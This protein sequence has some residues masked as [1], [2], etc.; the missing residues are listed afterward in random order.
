MKRLHSVLG[1]GAIAAVLLTPLILETP[2]MAQLQQAGQT[3][4]QTL[5]RQPQMQLQLSAA[6]QVVTTDD[7]GQPLVNWENLNGQAVVHPGDVLRYSLSG[8]NTSDRAVRNLVVTQPITQQ[9]KY[10]LGSAIWNQTTGAEITYSIDGGTTF[11][12]NP[13]IEVRL[14]DGR[15]ETRP[16]PAEAYTHIRWD[17]GD[18]V[19]AGTVVSATYQAQVQ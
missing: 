12:A 7:Q 18:A 17:F 13:T 14:P 19:S 11:V 3:V 8:Q 5:Q 9:M 1:L 2:V 16:A 4:A 6:K 10:V 15:V